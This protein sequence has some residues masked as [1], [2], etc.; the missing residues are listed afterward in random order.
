MQHPCKVGRKN[1]PHNLE[2]RGN[3]AILKCL[4]LSSE[5]VVEFKF[6]LI[7]QIPLECILSLHA[8]STSAL[9]SLIN[10]TCKLR[11]S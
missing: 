10:I 1:H 5:F 3:K 8:P 2:E 4:K 7:C 9:C 11:N 6:E